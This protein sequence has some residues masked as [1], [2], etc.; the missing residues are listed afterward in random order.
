MSE[1]TMLRGEW[2]IAYYPP[3]LWGRVT[4][5]ATLA[6]SDGRSYTFEGGYGDTDRR[7]TQDG[8]TLIAQ[9]LDRQGVAQTPMSLTDALTAARRAYDTA[10]RGEATHG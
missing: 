6:H 7:P 3:D 5:P 10:L 2:T 8:C 9:L 1:A 4:G